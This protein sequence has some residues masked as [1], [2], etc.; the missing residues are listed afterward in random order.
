MYKCVKYRNEYFEYYL[1][2]HNQNKREEAI[3]DTNHINKEF[4]KYA[5]M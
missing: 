2:Y 4:Y 1:I 5:R 3:F